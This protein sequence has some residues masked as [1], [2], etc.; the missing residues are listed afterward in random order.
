MPT[1]MTYAFIFSTKKYL[2]PECKLEWNIEA[3]TVFSR[4]PSLVA[5]SA[6]HVTYYNLPYWWGDTWY[7]HNSFGKTG[8]WSCFVLHAETFLVL[9]VV[10]LYQH[11]GVWL[12]TCNATFWFKISK[13]PQFIA[14]LVVLGTDYRCPMKPFFIEISNFLAW[15]DNLDR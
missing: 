1:N 5:S 7:F 13:M 11:I 12:C 10:E 8:V 3:I 6:S 14:F 15:A 4:L 2:V 9:V